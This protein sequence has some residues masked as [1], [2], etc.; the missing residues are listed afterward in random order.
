M[1]E[2]VL[3]LH[4]SESET[5]FPF[6][7][8]RPLSDSPDCASCAAFCEKELRMMRKKQVAIRSHST[9]NLRGFVERKKE[10]DDRK[11]GDQRNVS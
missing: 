4:Q 2:A 10:N 6:V 1:Y 5:N 3:A 11:I 9:A 7:E 8:L